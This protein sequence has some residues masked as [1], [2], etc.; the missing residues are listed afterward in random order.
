MRTSVVGCNLNRVGPKDLIMH[1]AGQ[2]ESARLFLAVS[3]WFGFS[4][5]EGPCGCFLLGRQ[6]LWELRNRSFWCGA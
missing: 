5:Q 3:K 6:L 1:T 4:S 2:I